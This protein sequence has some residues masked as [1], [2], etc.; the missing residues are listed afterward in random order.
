MALISRPGMASETKG[1]SVMTE[2]VVREAAPAVFRNPAI[3]L[4]TRAGARAQASASPR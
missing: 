4:Y 3:D 1:T 2:A